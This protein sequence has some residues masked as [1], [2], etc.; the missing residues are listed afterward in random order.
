MKPLA[1]DFA[2]RIRL[3]FSPGPRLRL[4]PVHGGFTRG[5]VS[6]LGGEVEGPRPGGCFP[7]GPSG[8]RPS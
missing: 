7:C 2:F 6:V 8:P 5:F 3:E 1:L 4:G